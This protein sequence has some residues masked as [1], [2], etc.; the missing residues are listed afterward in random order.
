[1]DCTRCCFQG[2]WRAGASTIADTALFPPIIVL[3]LRPFIAAAGGYEHTAALTQAGTVIGLGSE[4]YGQFTVYIR[5]ETP[6]HSPTFQAV[7]CQALN[8]ISITMHDHCLQHYQVR[9][10]HLQLTTFRIGKLES[11]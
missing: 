3:I 1:M 10:R 2:G 5:G 9:L 7:V 4:E 6:K 11:R 8:Y